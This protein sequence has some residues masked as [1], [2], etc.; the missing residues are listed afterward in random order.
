MENQSQS[1][2]APG[3][4]VSLNP[5]NHLTR[6]TKNLFATNLVPAVGAMALE[7]IGTGVT[8]LLL[9]VVLFVSAAFTPEMFTNPADRS[10]LPGLLVRLGIFVIVLS[11][12]NG[13]LAQM[14]TRAVITGSRGEKIPF[15]SLAPFV[16]KRYVITVLTL[17]A[18]MGL[19]V[20][21]FVLALLTNFIHVALAFLATVAAVIFAIVLALYMA[22]AFFIAVDDDQPKSV[23]WIMRRSAQLWK[24]SKGAVAL[25]FVL[26][27]V[28]AAVLSPLMSA[29]S[30]DPGAVRAV[31]TLIGLVVQGVLGLAFAAGMA[32]IY[33]EA[34]MVVDGGSGHSGGAMQ[35]HTSTELVE[36]PQDK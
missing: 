32:D 1:M 25:F 12:V 36:M 29:K 6:G 14:V 35:R 33:N 28:I 11:L 4:R 9:A 31:G 3:Q 8:A 20:G 5:I 18:V 22:Y 21:A 16:A 15:G 13:F 10:V 26:T 24:K 7:L 2:P 23:S 30:G 17:L 27:F 19:I 34:K